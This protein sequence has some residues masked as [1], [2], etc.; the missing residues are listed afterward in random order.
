MKQTKLIFALLALLPFSRAFAQEG[1]II[2]NNS[3][4]PREMHADEPWPD[5]MRLLDFD[6]D[7]NWDFFMAWCDLD[8]FNYAVKKTISVTSTLEQPVINSN[9]KVTFRV[10]DSFE[11]TGPFMVAGGAEFTVRRQDCLP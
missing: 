10:T 6:E 2:Y 5:N 1:E 11:I 8:N 3:F 4:E 9:D 7:S